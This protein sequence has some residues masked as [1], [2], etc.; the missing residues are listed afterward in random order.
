M[1]ETKNTICRSCGNNLTDDNWN[2][3]LKKRGDKICKK[4]LKS[5]YQKDD[6][7][8]MIHEIIKDHGSDDNR[9]LMIKLQNLR[10]QVI[11]ETHQEYRY[12]IKIIREAVENFPGEYYE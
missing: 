10:K 7:T 12:R 6:S 2:P 9:M 8:S 4:C 11:L 1:K 5:K 3:S